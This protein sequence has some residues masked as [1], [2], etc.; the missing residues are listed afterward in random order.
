MAE[1]NLQQTMIPVFCNL[2][3]SPGSGKRY[4]EE[5]DFA[6][7]LELTTDFVEANSQ[8]MVVNIK[9]YDGDSG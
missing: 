7:V 8:Y 9:E 2:K 1:V 5:L 3:I 6:Q 4:G